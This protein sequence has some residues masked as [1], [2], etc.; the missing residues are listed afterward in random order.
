M[1]SLSRTGKITI[2]AAVGALLL[3]LL[4]WFFTHG[5]A[6]APTTQ[7]GSFGTPAGSRPFGGTAPTNNT[8]GATDNSVQTRGVKQN[9][10]KISDGPVSGAT[11]I[12]TQNPTTTLARFIMQTDG[13]VY[14]LPLDIP[15]AILRSVS[16]TTIPGTVRT[17]W[18]ASS[19]AAIVQ[20]LD[21]QTTKTVYIDFPKNTFGATSTPPQH[22]QFFPDNVIDIAAS[23]DGARVAYLLPDDKLGAKGF[24]AHTDTTNTVNLFSLPMRQMLVSWPAPTTLLLQSKSFE[25]VPGVVF[26][27]GTKSGTLVPLVYGNG[28]T[29]TANKDFSRLIYQTRDG[30]VSTLI[31]VFATGNNYAIPANP[32]PER[33]AFGTATT[34]MYCSVEATAVG[35]PFLDLWHQGM[36]TRNTAVASVDVVSTKV[37]GIATPGFSGGKA[38]DIA[39]MAVSPDGKYLLYVARGDRSLWGV[40]LTQ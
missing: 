6:P 27:V 24:L 15:G 11:F 29:A 3:A 28:I 25:G 31:H 38:A 34:T 40:R 23:P 13:H 20:Y 7:T 30:V 14:D 32:A 39:E 26:A 4:V 1:P 16:N 8:S 9:I 18:V 12:Q 33:C 2:A 36:A 5:S 21:N 22:I 37:T 19:S 10:F 17:L 35:G